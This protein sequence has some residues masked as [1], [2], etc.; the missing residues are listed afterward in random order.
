MF[1]VED[2]PVSGMSSETS[3]PITS[4]DFSL[5]LYEILSKCLTLLPDCLWEALL[6]STAIIQRWNLPIKKINEEEKEEEM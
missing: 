4:L 3:A 2:I 1:A 6:S 5:V